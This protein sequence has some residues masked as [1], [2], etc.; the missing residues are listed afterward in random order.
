MKLPLKNEIITA[1]GDFGSKRSHGDLKRWVEANGGT[2]V[3]GVSAKVTH[4]I[5]SKAHWK[6]QSSLGA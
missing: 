5:C 3:T 2:W 6:E 4:L 1:T